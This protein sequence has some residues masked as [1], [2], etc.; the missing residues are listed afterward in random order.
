MDG[1]LLVNKEKGVT[2]RD[3]V[4]KISKQFK[5]KKVGHAGTLDPLA[6]GLLIICINRAT[7]I[8][9]IITGY[10][11]EY[12]ATVKLGIKTDTGDLEGNIIEEKTTKVN[13]Q[14][15]N[16]KIDSFQKKYMQKVPLYSAVRVDGKKLYEYARNNEEVELPER[17]VEIKKIELLE[18]DEENQTFSFKT[19]VSK[20]TYIRSLVEDIAEELNTVGTMTDLIRTKQGEYKIEDAKILDD[21]EKSDAKEIITGLSQ[22]KKIIIDE[23]SI[24]SGKIIE[25]NYT[26]EKVLFVNEKNE[27]LAIYKVYEKDNTKMKPW[28]VFK[29]EE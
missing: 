10:E 8:V 15:T 14:Q 28:K 29:L 22:F 9:E 17:E 4:N 5:T 26:E 27:P 11:K 16:N 25:N 1:I 24:K 2:S 23:E 20:G 7:K 18:F 6:T 13:K 12:I 21:I 19:T 3:V